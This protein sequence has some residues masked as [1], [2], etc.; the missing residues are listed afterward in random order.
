[1]LDSPRTSPAQVALFLSTLTLPDDLPGLAG[2][3]SAL[4]AECAISTQCAMSASAIPPAGHPWSGLCEQLFAALAALPFC[5]W[6]SNESSEVPARTGK[7]AVSEFLL[8]SS[9]RQKRSMGAL[10]WLPFGKEEEGWRKEEA[11]RCCIDIV[12]PVFLS[13]EFKVSTAMVP[14]NS[15]FPL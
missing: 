8:N 15:T 14:G 6:P 1:M 5:L 11:K 3:C 12:H 7:I 13:H 10:W 4:Q 2:P 9:Y